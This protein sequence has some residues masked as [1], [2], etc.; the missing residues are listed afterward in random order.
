MS[1]GSRLAILAT[2]SLLGPV[3]AAQQTQTPAPSGRGRI[4]GAGIGAYPQCNED[5]LRKYRDA[6]IHDVTAYLTTL[7]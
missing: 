2:L 6:D 7:K 4:G 5:L 1:R 3:A